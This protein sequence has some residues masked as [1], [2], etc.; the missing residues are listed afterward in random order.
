M[1]MRMMVSMTSGM[2]LMFC[3]VANA[4]DDDDVESV[5]SSTSS[6]SFCNTAQGLLRRHDIIQ[7][8]QVN[9]QH[10]KASTTPNHVPKACIDFL[11]HHR[12]QMLKWRLSTLASREPKSDSLHHSRKKIQGASI[13]TRTSHLHSAH[14]GIKDLF[15]PEGSKISL[16]NIKNVLD[17]TK[18]I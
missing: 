14:H 6:V 1:M 3:A 4:D 13:P 17:V 15:L 18:K 12:L 2:L 8:N 7:A 10:E 5:I 16:Q 9:L 11:S